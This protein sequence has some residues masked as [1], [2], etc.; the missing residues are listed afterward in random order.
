MYLKDIQG[1]TTNIIK[2]DSSLSA[3]YEY[4]DFGET[5]EL[6]GGG[7]DNEICYTGAIYD[8]TTGLYYMNA[9]YYAPENGRFI[10]QDTYRGELNDPG[11]WHLYTYCANNPINYVDPSGH[12]TY[13][14]KSKLNAEMKK[15]A[16]WLYNYAVEQKTKNSKYLQHKKQRVITLKGTMNILSK[17]VEKVRSGGE[18]DLKAKK[19]WKPKTYGATSFTY[20][21]KK[22][23]GEDVGNLHFG[24][25][26]AVLFGKTALCA[27]AGLYQIYSGTSNLKYFTSY[28]DDPRDTKHIKLGY[29]IWKEKYGKRV[30]GCGW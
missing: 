8:D 6:T 20:E 4:S 26:G 5:E 17:F 30:Y 19:K 11:Q 28:F 27:G 7:F 9:R 23:Q 18:W 16:K 29:E 2:E 3:A 10:S 22:L 21:T 14:I 1:S 15:N 24:Y 13:N 25:V 12:K